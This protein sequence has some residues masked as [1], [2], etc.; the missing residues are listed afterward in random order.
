MYMLWLQR[1]GVS[2]HDINIKEKKQKLWL[3]LYIIILF[4]VG[5]IDLHGIGCWCV[6]V[7]FF[8][9]NGIFGCIG[10]R[11]LCMHV[12]FYCGLIIWSIFVHLIY[13]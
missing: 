2:L 4:F 11:Y 8:G 5:G 7:R 6:S 13:S 12:E 3:L 9:E 1:P 10:I